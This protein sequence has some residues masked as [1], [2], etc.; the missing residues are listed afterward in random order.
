MAVTRLKRIERETE[1]LGVL[2]REVM[3]V[4]NARGAGFGVKPVGKGIAE[5]VDTTARP[6]ACLEN[7]DVVA[8][9][10]EF[11]RRRQTG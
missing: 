2:E 10:C 11:V 3:V 9:L 5:C 4:W 1:Q 8:C 7:R 6:R